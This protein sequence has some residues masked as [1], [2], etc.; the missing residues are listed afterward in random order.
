MLTDI[1]IY[2]KMKYLVFNTEEAA[3][4]RTNQEAIARG[5]GGTS[6]KY[7]WVN[8]ETQ[9]NK[10]ALLI[11]E[12]DYGTLTPAEISQ[13]KDSVPFPTPLGP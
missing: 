6:T 7:W 3:A 11:P 10:F 5:C 13:L 1:I 9:D 4:N 12:G 8:R 2:I